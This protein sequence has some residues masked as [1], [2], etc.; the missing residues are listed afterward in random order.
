MHEAMRR[1]T[2][3]GPEFEE[4]RPLPASAPRRATALAYYLPQ[5]HPIAENDQWWGKGF[6]EW[7]SLARALPRFE[8]HYQPRVPRDLGHYTLDGTAVLRRQVGLA[9]GAGLRGF[10]FY[11]YWFNGRRL[12]DQPLE[13]FL[14][15]RSLDFPFCLMWANENWTRRWDGSDQRGADLAGLARRATRPH[16]STVSR[17]I[18]ATPAISACRAG[19]C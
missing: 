5:F 17:A 2:V 15:D 14:D 11:F 12:L 10:V 13:A 3:P 16:W 19:R 6:T 7:T 8:G 1:F 4:V 18:S 9:R